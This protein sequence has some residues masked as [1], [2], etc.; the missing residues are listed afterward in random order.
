MT[1]EPN[2]V[3]LK[4]A[5]D[6]A[7]SLPDLTENGT[8]AEVRQDE[9]QDLW[10]TY[11]DTADLR[12]ALTASDWPGLGQGH[13]HLQSR[14]VEVLVAGRGAAARE[15]RALLW[16]PAPDGTIATATRVGSG[17]PTGLTLAGE[18]DA[19]AG[20]GRLPELPLPGEG[21]AAAEAGGSSGVPLADAG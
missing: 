4:L 5:I 9:S 11:W 14:R 16:L 21:V 20:E 7:F 19:P 2:E 12:L 15:R 3:E 1:D 8:V 13:G 17:G 10:A 18:G 6:G